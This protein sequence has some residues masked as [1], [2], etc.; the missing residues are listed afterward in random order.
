MYR[1]VV[2]VVVVVALFTNLQ[3]WSGGY[4]VHSCTLINMMLLRLLLRAADALDLQM[5]R[6]NVRLQG[7]DRPERHAL[8]VRAGVVPA[9]L[10]HCAF[11]RARSTF[12]FQHRQV[13]RVS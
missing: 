8:A 3:T 12:T 2:V 6:A 11:V 10:V 9:L 1:L 5:D 13:L 7:A 4:A